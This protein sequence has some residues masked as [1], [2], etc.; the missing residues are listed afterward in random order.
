MG[1]ASL[2]WGVRCPPPGGR[3]SS[4][5]VTDGLA[6]APAP[7][8]PG[9]ALGQPVP[10]RPATALRRAVRQHGDWDQTSRRVARALRRHL[11][12]PDI[13]TTAERAGDPAAYQQHLIHAEPD[14]SFSVVG[15]VWRPGQITPS[16]I[17]SPGA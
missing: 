4:Q 14:G 8:R 7:A 2:P 6:T 3:R 1:P 10:G 16:M 13:L 17:T 9:P 5:E 11:P 12:G 15:L